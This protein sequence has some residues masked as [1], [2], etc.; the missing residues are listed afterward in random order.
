MWVCAQRFTSEGD[1]GA[2]EGENGDEYDRDRREYEEGVQY[3]GGKT[4]GSGQSLNHFS[5]SIN[6]ISFF[7]QAHRGLG[8]RTIY[9]FLFTIT[10]SVLTRIWPPLTDEVLSIEHPAGRHL[11]CS[12]YIS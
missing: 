9:I 3:P 4:N 1:A 5:F 10:E 8:G 2:L 6:F 12:T 7:A 11:H